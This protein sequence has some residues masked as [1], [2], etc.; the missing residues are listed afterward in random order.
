MTVRHIHKW[1]RA[2][3]FNQSWTNQPWTVHLKGSWGAGIRLVPINPHFMIS[4][5]LF[6]L[7]CFHFQLNGT[8]FPLDQTNFHTLWSF[9]RNAWS[10]SSHHKKMETLQVS[11]VGH[12]LVFTSFSLVDGNGLSSQNNMQKNTAGLFSHHKRQCYGSK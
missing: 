1:P 5:E 8:W 11:W 10:N 4:N 6:K 12:W 9:Y 3:T 7:I 2:R